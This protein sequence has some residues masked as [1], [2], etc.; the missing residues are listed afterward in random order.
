MSIRTSRW[1]DGVPCW[2]D[3][4]V[5]DVTAAKHFY[6]EVLGWSYRSTEIEFGD[7][8][9]AE[10][11]GA[12]A[13]GIGPLPPGAPAATKPRTAAQPRLSAEFRFTARLRAAADPRAATS[14]A[15]A[16]VYAQPGQSA[17]G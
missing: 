17:A 13:A 8:S 1:P 11:Q 10:T 6:A 2:A 16:R 4:G 3:L 14:L 9:I 5:P 7:Y 12:A 15:P